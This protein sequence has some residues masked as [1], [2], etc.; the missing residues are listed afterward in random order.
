MTQRRVLM[1]AAL[2]LA[3]LYPLVPA[4][5]WAVEAV[6]GF[7]P[8]LPQQALNIF[9]F[10][11]LALALNLQVGYAGLLQLGMGAFFAVGAFT[12]GILTVEKY[13]FQIGFW[14]ALCVT[15]WVT[16]GLGLAIAAPTMRLRGNYL[17]IVTL[18][19]GEVVRVML[20]NLENIT[21][22]ARGLNPVPPPWMPDWWAGLFGLQA[23]FMLLYYVSLALLV[24]L[25]L[26]FAA[27]ERA[28]MGR[29]LTA[30]REDALAAACIGLSPARIRGAAFACGAA[31]AGV[32]GV[33][34]ATRLTTTA[35][36]STYDFTCSVMVLCC[37][38]IGGL[39]NP[40]GVVLGTALLL[41]FDNVVSPLLTRLLQDA[42]THGSDGSDGSDNV[43]L[44]FSNWRWLIFGSVL[45]LMM[46]YRP[47]GLWGRARG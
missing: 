2:L 13:P 15:P 39:G 46:R 44:T 34:Y 31:L 23:S 45:V 16:G 10:A 14:G 35:E 8:R 47:Q 38:I 43:L 22:G 7:A 25:L 20:L 5:D 6:T 17:A 18:G 30:L 42:T 26:L 19:F 33:L 29:A 40:V 11:I 24:A 36:P 32:A 1:A 21:D 9:I 37:V 27:M 3:V 41:G 4:L 12:C 28:P